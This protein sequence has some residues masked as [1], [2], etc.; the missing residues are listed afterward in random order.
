MA[1]LLN[2]LIAKQVVRSHEYKETDSINS[3]QSS[4]KSHPLWVTLYLY[5]CIFC[6][7][8]CL[9]SCII[10]SRY[11]YIYVPLF[12]YIFVS[13]YPC[14]PGRISVSP[15]VSLYP[16]M[17]VSLYICLLVS[18]YHYIHVFLYPWDLWYLCYPCIPISLYP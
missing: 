15:A 7:F 10:I 17:I 13:L 2:K 9:N 16:C 8:V 1:Y 6:I 4:L 5:Y 3:V 14:I 12:F 18:L 11:R